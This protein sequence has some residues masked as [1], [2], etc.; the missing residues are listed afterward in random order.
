MKKRST[1]IWMLI[2]L[3][4]Y[5]TYVKSAPDS[6]TPPSLVNVLS[7]AALTGVKLSMK[8]GSLNGQVPK[9]LYKC[10]G[11]LEAASFYTLYDRL[12]NSNFSPDERGHANKF[13]N[14]V[15]GKKYTKHGLLK[16]YSATGFEV[17]EPMPQFSSNEMGQLDKFSRTSAGEKLLVKHVMQSNSVNV[18]VQGRIQQL[19]SSCSG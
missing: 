5:S 19:I 16:I 9:S 12:V 10:I 13:L 3:F 14:S 6:N 7:E 17:P 4:A 18:A 15:T 8:R 2:L 1:A 11:Q